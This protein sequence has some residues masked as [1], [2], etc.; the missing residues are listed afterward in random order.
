M[1]PR[2]SEAQRAAVE[3]HLDAHMNPYEIASITG[4]SYCHVMTIRKNLAIWGTTGRPALSG[5]GRPRALTAEMEDVI[6]PLQV[7]IK[8]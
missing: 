7:S 4:V 2:L 3:I 5:F 6:I 1:P 8:Y